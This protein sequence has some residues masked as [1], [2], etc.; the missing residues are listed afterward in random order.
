[1]KITTVIHPIEQHVIDVVTKLR[2]ERKLKQHH[3]AE[4]IQTGNSFIGNVE[5]PRNPAKYNFKHINSLAAYFDL[6]PRFFFPEK[7]LEL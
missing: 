3:L 4:I 6:S 7:P 1:M 5:N 2:L